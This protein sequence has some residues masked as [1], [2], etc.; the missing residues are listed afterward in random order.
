M[1]FE[2]MC[3]RD[4]IEAV[5]NIRIR[6]LSLYQ[7]AM[8][9]KSAV[10]LYKANRSNE[11][12]EFIGDSVLNLIIANYLYVKFPDEDEG[13]MTKLRTRIVSGQCLSNLAKQMK[14]QDYIRMNDKAL[15]QGWNNNPRILEDVFE[16]LIGAIFL[17]QGMFSAQEYVLN[18]IHAHIN[19]DDLLTDNNYKDML[20]RYTQQKGYDLPV[21]IV[22]NE[23][24]PNHNKT[25]TIQVNVNANVLGEG[26]ANNKKKAEQLAAKSAITCLGV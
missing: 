4:E 18:K 10:K 16:A 19:F 2:N 1:T 12:L 17:D 5:L 23:H 6:T 20:M 11:R 9:H 25:F 3:T 13:F 8:L 14:L 21:Y 26:Y 24:G 15:R 7:E 22:T